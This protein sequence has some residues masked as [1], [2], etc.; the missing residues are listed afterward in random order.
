MVNE[1]L[2]KR[3]AKYN[4]LKLKFKATVGELQATIT[5]LAEEKGTILASQTEDA[6]ALREV[7]IRAAHFEDLYERERTERDKLS[8]TLQKLMME[9]E[10][11]NQLIIRQASQDL[12]R[13]GSN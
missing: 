7:E 6:M 9:Q 2:A 4:N 11:T 10:K 12:I 1:M 8:A 5:R 3:T 13:E